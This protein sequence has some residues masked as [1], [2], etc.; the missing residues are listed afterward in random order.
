M[1]VR[2]CELPGNLA[3]AMT[4]WAAPR[5]PGS[6]RFHVPALRI[7]CPVSRNGQPRPQFGSTISGVRNAHGSRRRPIGGR[8]ASPT[9]HRCAEPSVPSEVYA[10]TV[11]RRDLRA[12]DAPFP[13][14]W[15]CRVLSLAGR[16]MRKLHQMPRAPGKPILHATRA[17]DR[18]RAWYVSVE[19]AAANF[20]AS[21]ERMARRR[22]LAMEPPPDSTAQRS[23]CRMKFGSAPGKTNRQNSH[24]SQLRTVEIAPSRMDRAS[25]VHD[26]ESRLVRGRRCFVSGSFQRS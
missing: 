18:P 25:N 3:P 1:N 7:K 16:S 17:I 8:D 24:C 26:K 15:L 21:S 11:C 22:A 13:V 19:F 20:L 4:A 2:N 23:R 6:P 12:C 9:L 10:V 14:A 5:D